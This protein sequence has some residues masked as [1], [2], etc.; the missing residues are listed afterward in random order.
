MTTKAAIENLEDDRARRILDAAVRHHIAPGSALEL[1]PV[2][3]RELAAAFDLTDASLSPVSEGELVQQALLVLAQDPEIAAAIQS[4]AAQPAA[5][6]QKFDFGASL[7]LT[8]A[9][10]IVLQTRYKFERHKDGAWSITLE[11]KPTSEAILKDLV[12][13]LLGYTK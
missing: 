2:L 12:R 13:K 4:M 1:T 8:A 7:A 11:K 9:A 6:P 3:R 5:G 10:L